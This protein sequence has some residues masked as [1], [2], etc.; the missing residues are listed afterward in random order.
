MSHYTVAVITKNGNY[1][2]ALEPFDENL[3]VEPYIEKTVHE[4]IEQMKKRKELNEENIKK[5][6]PDAY[7][8]E[9]RY[10]KIDWNDNESIVEAFKRT[11][12]WNNYDDEGNIIST[13]NP[14]SKW[15]WYSLGGRWD[16]SLKLKKGAKVIKESE[17]SFF[18]K[19]E[20]KEGYTDFAQVK[21]IDFTPDEKAKRHAER[22][23]DVNVLGKPLLENE[24]EEEIRSFYKKEYYRRNYGTKKEYVRCCSEF[25]TFAILYEGVWYEPDSMGWF[26]CCSATKDQ[27]KAYRDKF[28]E[29]IAKLSPD[30]YIAV[31]DCHI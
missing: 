23:W 31:V 2:K 20:I 5:G 10:G 17:P 16:G 8:F 30:D 7:N 12:T 6:S 14:N 26:G 19:E 22:F 1:E 24:K 15:D 25:M 13:Y 11:E 28:R 9:E 3:E 29:I 21:D 27:Y 18:N 4:I